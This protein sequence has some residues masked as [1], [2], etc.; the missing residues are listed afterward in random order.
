MTAL[1]GHDGMYLVAP[2]S[3]TPP[4]WTRLLARELLPPSDADIDV[5]RVELDAWQERPMISAA[6]VVVPAPEHGS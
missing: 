5:G 4:G 6:M 3:V 2:Q 1:D